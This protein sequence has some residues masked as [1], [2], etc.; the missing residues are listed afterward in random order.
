MRIGSLCTGV[1]ALDT[2][3]TSVLGGELAWVADP[4][5][6]AT[7]YLSHHHPDTPNVGDIREIDWSTVEPVDWLTAGFPCQPISNAGKRKG[8]ADDRWLWPE[9]A[10]AVRALRPRH[11]YLENVGALRTRGFAD[12][13]RD[14][15]AARYDLRWCSIRASA[16]GAPHRRLRMFILATAT[17]SVDADGELGHQRRVTAAGETSCWWSHAEPRR[18]DRARATAHP[19]HVRHQRAVPPRDGRPGPANDSRPVA[20]TPRERRPQRLAQAAG[21]QR[22]QDFTRSRRDAWGRFGDAIARWEHLTARPAPAPTAPTGRHGAQRL[23]AAAVEWMMG[24]T[25]VTD[26][27]GLTRNQKL[28]LLGNSVVPQQAAHALR[29]LLNDEAW[30]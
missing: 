23:N 4:D 25:G 6:A 22:R 1:A 14:L 21:K 17:A 18:R 28:K 15:A 20:D 26:V 10:R 13:A 16:V 9:V 24:L 7:A 30:T 12:V 5:P 11:V 2:A 29:L 8:T 3:V 19:P 27:E